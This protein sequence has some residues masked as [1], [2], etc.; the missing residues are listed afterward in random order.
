MA[1]GTKRPGALNRDEMVSALGTIQTILWPG[2]SI[3]AE[4]DADTLDAIARVFVVYGMAPTND[5]VR[6]V[7]GDK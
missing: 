2:G 6:A 1:K 5:E 3:T 7:T 4:W